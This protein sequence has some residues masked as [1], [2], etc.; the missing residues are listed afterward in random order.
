MIV[1]SAY[2]LFASAR[3]TLPACASTNVTQAKYA[4]T[5]SLQ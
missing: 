2:G 5:I 1:L 3:S 4:L